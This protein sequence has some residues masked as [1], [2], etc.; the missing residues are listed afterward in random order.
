MAP[1]EPAFVAAPAAG[2][3]RVGAARRPALATTRVTRRRP[4]RAPLP[5]PLVAVVAAPR[6]G[7]AAPTPPSSSPVGTTTTTTTAPPPH[8]SRVMSPIVGEAAYRAALRSPSADGGLVITAYVAPYCRACAAMTRR[9]ERLAA[10]YG[11]RDVHWYALDVTEPANAPVVRAA[12][13][14]AL[15]TF[16]LSTT[17]AG[18]V[19]GHLDTLVVPPAEAARLAD[20]VALYTS[21]AF[22]VRE[23]SFE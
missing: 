2:G 22:D 6:P 7:G 14:D 18:G 15:P 9:V 13:L 11:G 20:R 3:A 12:R 21:A 23:F 5:P 10:A 8:H 16:V 19:P 4:R 17:A 1:T